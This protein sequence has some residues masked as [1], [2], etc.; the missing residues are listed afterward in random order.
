MTNFIDRVRHGQPINVHRGTS[1]SWCYIDDIV[2]GCRLLMEGWDGATYE[3]FNIGRSDPRP[4]TEVAELICRLLQQPTDL[5]QLSD[6]GPLVTPV[7]NASFEK[8]RRLLRFEAKVPLE[9]GVER[10]IAWQLA[11]LS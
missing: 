3:A 11:N 8:A 4:T 1:R 6:P 7:K 9:E 10:T 5:I 2:E